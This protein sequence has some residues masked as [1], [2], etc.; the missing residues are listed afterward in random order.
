MTETKN[1]LMEGFAELLA[2]GRRTPVLRKP[3]EFGMEYE[4]VFPVTRRGA[5]EWG[6]LFPLRF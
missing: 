2:K 6:G 5:I 1:I 3:D 4:D